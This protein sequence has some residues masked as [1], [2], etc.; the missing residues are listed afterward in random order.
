MEYLRVLIHSGSQAAFVTEHA[1]QLL[2]LPR[3][4]IAAEVFGLGE[5]TS[6]TSKTQVSCEIFPRFPSDFSMRINFLVLPRI[7]HTL[8]SRK[9]DIKISTAWQNQMQ[10]LRLTNQGPSTRFWEPKKWDT[11]FNRVSKNPRTIF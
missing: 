9:I 10:I 3:Q 7:T 8:P 1:E 5:G 2:G 4:K 6:K 11:F